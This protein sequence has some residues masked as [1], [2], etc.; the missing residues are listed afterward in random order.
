MAKQSQKPTEGLE[1]DT[2]EREPDFL[3]YTTPGGKVRLE[4]F[5]KDENIWLTQERIAQLFGVD[6]SVVTKHLKNIY[7]SGELDEAVTSA[8][9][10]QVQ[11]EGSRQVTRSRIW[12]TERLLE[13]CYSKK[14]FLY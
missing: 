5:I 10:A 14:V 6:R 3:L 2:F 4:I 9:F 12:A 7:E 8:K 1:I 13:I 11:T